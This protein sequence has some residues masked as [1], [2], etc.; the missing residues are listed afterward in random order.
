[1]FV[2]FEDS[3]QEFRGNV[4]GIESENLNEVGEKSGRGFREFMS[5]KSSPGS[6]VS[7]AYGDAHMP[8][9]RQTRHPLPQYRLTRPTSEYGG[10]L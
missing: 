2:N 4:R 5:S 3:L 1:M 8:N 6:Y 10:K 7:E 9:W